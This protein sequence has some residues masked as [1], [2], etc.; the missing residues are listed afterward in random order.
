MGRSKRVIGGVLDGDHVAT[1]KGAEPGYTAVL[2]NGSQSS[3][4]ELRE[5]HDGEEAMVLKTMKWPLLA[6]AGA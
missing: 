6:G 2:Q 3:E 1:P 5:G 4:Y